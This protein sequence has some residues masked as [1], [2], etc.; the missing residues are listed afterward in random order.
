MIKFSLLTFLSCA[1]SNIIQKKIR[2]FT[3][4]LLEENA[5]ILVIIAATLT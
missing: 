3:I 1:Q 4:I 2:I 5:K